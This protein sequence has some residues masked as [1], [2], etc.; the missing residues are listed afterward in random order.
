ML[1]REGEF[2]ST[3]IKPDPFPF[4][5]RVARFAP[6]IRINPELLR[7]HVVM[8]ARAVH[9]ALPHKLP[10]PQALQSRHA[11]AAAALD[12]LMAA[13]EAERRLLML[14]EREGRRDVALDRV[15]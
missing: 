14:L 12:R 1:V 8:A 4:A 3:M 11:V 10:L 15:A 7:V 6:S 9:T 13:G 2:R 5:R